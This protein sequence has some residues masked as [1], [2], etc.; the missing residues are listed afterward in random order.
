MKRTKIN[1]TTEHNIT[2]IQIVF[3]CEI[4]NVR[5][6]TLTENN[7]KIYVYTIK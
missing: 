2:Y 6:P 7:N 5:H 3:V 1:K 4:N